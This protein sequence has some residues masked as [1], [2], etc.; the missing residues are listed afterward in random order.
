MPAARPAISMAASMT[1]DSLKGA[2]L[3]TILLACTQ[4]N[5]LNVRHLSEAPNTSVPVP[6]C[7]TTPLN[8]SH[9]LSVNAA[10]RMEYRA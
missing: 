7:T 8:R 9:T 2:L 10:E 5:T 4:P 1:E 6:N 3:S